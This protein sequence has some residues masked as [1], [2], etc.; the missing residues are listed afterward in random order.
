MKKIRNAILTLSFLASFFSY[1]GLTSICDPQQDLSKYASYI[2]KL[3]DE[4]SSEVADGNAFYKN[5]EITL[6]GVP[7][8]YFDH[9]KPS[10]FI[11]NWVCD[12]PCSYES[13]ASFIR[14]QR[15]IKIKAIDVFKSASSYL[16][17]ANDGRSSA[18]LFAGLRNEVKFDGYYNNKKIP[19]SINS[20]VDEILKEAKKTGIPFTGD[21]LESVAGFNDIFLG[22]Y[23]GD[24]PLVIA[25]KKNPKKPFIVNLTGLD[26]KG[27]IV[28]GHSINVILEGLTPTSKIIIVN[29]GRIS[30]SIELSSLSQI[31]IKSALIKTLRDSKITDVNY[32]MFWE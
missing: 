22:G 31:G 19:P 26:K 5:V 32:S 17:S 27:N 11:F 10:Q 8:S 18:E 12:G 4:S 7:S 24:D 21:K 23:N 3:T 30:D 20:A 9:L 2:D 1:A 13:E 16:T 14:L 6:K 29:N 25:L 28:Q 15:G